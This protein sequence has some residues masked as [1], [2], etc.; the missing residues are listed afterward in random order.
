MANNQTSVTDAEVIA[1]LRQKC[2]RMNA[3]LLEIGNY[4]HDHSAGPAQPDALWTV[5]LMAYEAEEELPA[6]QNS[7]PPPMPVGGQGEA[8]SPLIARPLAEW[9]DDDGPVFWWAWCGHGWAGEPAWVGQPDDSDWPG[10]HTHWT[11]HP[12]SPATKR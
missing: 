9:H 3:A 10:Y 11:T 1:L 2:E 5:R 4:A 8:E 6:Q 7:P 12:Q